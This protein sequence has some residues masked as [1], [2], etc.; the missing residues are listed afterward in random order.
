[1]AE[2]FDGTGRA[3]TTRP[4][5]VPLFA[6]TTTD[7]PVA[8]MERSESGVPLSREIPG[9]RCAP[10]GLRNSKSPADVFRNN[11]DK[12]F[13]R[14]RHR[15]IRQIGSRQAHRDSDFAERMRDWGAELGDTDGNGVDQC[16][17]SQ[18]ADRNGL[19]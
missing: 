18:Q 5:G 16:E 14:V 3:R 10:P 13:Q 12:R 15:P 19:A 6:G 2:T 4:G 8:R 11:L 1:M 17:A 9:L 7:R